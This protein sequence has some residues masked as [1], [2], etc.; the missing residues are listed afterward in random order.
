MHSWA[1]RDH[2]SLK[3]QMLNVCV[4]LIYARRMHTPARI[5]MDQNKWMRRTTNNNNNNNNRIVSPKLA[6]VPEVGG[7][8]HRW[9]SVFLDNV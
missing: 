1:R 5:R 4:K 3:A 6:R 7:L 8:V 9:E 2:A